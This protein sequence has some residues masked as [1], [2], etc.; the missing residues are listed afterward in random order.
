MVHKNNN[1]GER[2]QF[3]SRVITDNRITIP[4]EVCEAYNIKKG[5]L[6]RVEI[7]EIIK[8]RV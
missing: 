3:I 5:N 4:K 1:K 7:I 8:K 2:V 6:V